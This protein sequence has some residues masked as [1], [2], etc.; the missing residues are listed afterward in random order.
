MYFS[1]VSSDNPC[2]SGSV[3]NQKLSETPRKVPERLVRND[4]VPIKAETS[5]QYQQRAAI[6]F[7]K[8]FTRNLSPFLSKYQKKESFHSINKQNNS[9]IRATKHLNTTQPH[10]SLSAQL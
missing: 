7:H 3:V 2:I 8:W 4:E 6:S 9:K 5:V 1:D 10:S